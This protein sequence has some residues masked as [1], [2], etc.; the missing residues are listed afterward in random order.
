M[1]NE[2]PKTQ[3]GGLKLMTVFVVVL[4]LHV[5]V[6]G[7]ISAYHLLSHKENSNT[8]VTE[9]DADKDSTEAKTDDTT[10]NA[11]TDATTGTAPTDATKTPAPTIETNGEPTTTT[12][13]AP[14]NDDA[15]V[16]EKPTTGNAIVTNP[17]TTTS[18]PTIASQPNQT[19]PLATASV[20]PT[21]T[22]IAPAPVIATA[23]DYKVK[24]GD[25]L[26]KIARTHH[27]KVADI[28][29]FNN[30]QSNNLK[31]GQT[32]KLNAATTTAT[33]VQ[34][35]P[36]ATVT[37]TQ[38]PIVATNDS[39]AT[40]YTVIKGDTLTKIARHFKT[41]PSAIMTANNLSD[42]KKLAIGAKLKIP[43]QEARNQETAAPAPKPFKVVPPAQSS[44][45]VMVR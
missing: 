39:S 38:T 40:T 23:N 24:A 13:A 6:I 11:T 8:T 19:A 2:N 34:T 10:H 5:L 1:E 21:T 27:L 20:T 44:D 22:E 33:T 43:S 18:T 41:T 45:L 32:L 7:G 16:G 15:T 35:A 14:L 30:L 42:P 31:I 4:I 36:A 9:K 12:A 29:Q 37:P 28:K 3:T 25:S 17:T 26:Y